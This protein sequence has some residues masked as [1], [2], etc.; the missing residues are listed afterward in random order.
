MTTF[1]LIRRV[2]LA[3]MAGGSVLAAVQLYANEPEL[4]DESQNIFIPHAEDRLA[5]LR[6]GAV[7]N[8]DEIQIRYEFP[9]DNPSW[10]HQ[11]WI[12]EGG[13]WIRY[14][15]GALGQDPHGLYEDRI[16]MM[17]DDGSVDGFGHYG[18]YMTVH[19]G[20]RTLS[21]A[22]SSE[23]VSEHPVLG[24]EMGRTDIRKYL[25]ATRD[26]EDE[27]VSW[28]RLKDDAEIQAMRERGEFLDLWQWRAHRSH[29]LGYSDN[30]YVL[31]Y[32]LNSEGTG[33]FTDNW[34]SDADQPAWMYDSDVTGITH[35]D[36][37][38]LMAREYDQDDWYYL[39][40]H[41]A[42]PFDPDHDWQ[43]GDALPQRF[44]REPSGSRGAIRAAGGYEDGAW[45]IQLTRSLD[46]PNPL[47]SKTLRDGEVYQA[48]FAVHTNASGARWHLVSHP[49]SLGL[50]VEDADLVAQRIEGDLSEADVTWTELQV[51]YPGQTTWQWLHREEHPGKAAVES[52]AIG[53]GDIHLS[54]E[55]IAGFAVDFEKERA[56]SP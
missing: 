41:I 34:D 19:D 3:A 44:L 4:V 35:L 56:T 47:D 8:D 23:E 36:R 42:K 39:S 32:R 20:M 55:E 45:R 1:P 33:P 24:E 12:Y 13:E 28:D 29:P 46:A 7:Y 51:Y 49:Q 43:E 16:S 5:T 26:A 14:G 27:E 31:Q 53:I 38:R 6:V 17:L 18:G 37:D 54:L 22:A 10:Y 40:E 48:A 25:P 9:T 2:S 52:R 50:G 21:D 30:N 15:S 11:Y